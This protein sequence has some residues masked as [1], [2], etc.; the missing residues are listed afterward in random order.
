MPTASHIEEVNS[1]LFQF[2]GKGLRL[3]IGVSSFHEFIARQ[4]HDDGIVRPHSLPDFFSHL[5]T[6]SHSV[7]KRSP[8]LVIPFVR[9]G[10]KKLTDQISCAPQDLHGI[11]S[12]IF[13]ALGGL[14]ELVLLGRDLIQFKGPG[15]LSR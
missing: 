3:F 15:T 1:H 14:C 8:I 5:Q 11:E 10:R 6:E 2:R 12:G 9:Q 7:L 13:G 4:P